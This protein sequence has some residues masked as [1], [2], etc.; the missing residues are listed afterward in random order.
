MLIRL[1][2]FAGWSASLLFPYNPNRVSQD[3]AFNMVKW[4]E[5]L[6]YTFIQMVIYMIPYIQNS[7]MNR[8]NTTVFDLISDLSVH[9]EDLLSYDYYID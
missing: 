7:N 2:I 5:K 9:T 4:D 6:L 1:H 8:R 3:R